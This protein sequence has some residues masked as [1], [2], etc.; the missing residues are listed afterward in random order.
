MPGRSL[1]ALLLCSFAVLAQ[2]QP[3]HTWREG[4]NYFLIQP[5]QPS[6]APPGKVEVTEV[7]SYACP[8][9]N[10]FYPIA[11][12]IKSSLP[13]NAVMDFL[14]AAFNPSEDWPMF[15]R[16]YFTAQALGVAAKTHDAM[17]NAVWKSGEL[18]VVDRASNTLKQ[19][20]PTIEDAARFYHR[21]AGVDEQ[22]FLAVARSFSVDLKMKRADQLIQ[23]YQADST[24]TLVIDGKYRVTPSSAGGYN[25]LLAVVKY[26]VAKESH[27]A[28]P[29]ASRSTP[30]SPALATN[31]RAH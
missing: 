2:A 4:E 28:A 13:S 26:L 25:E 12:R 19:P 6:N 17:F 14:P 15:Q 27:A 9:C 20:A 23:A 11:E 5:P 30:K 8:A 7:F 18:A 16:A 10:A 31:R 1:L 22:Q 29:H 3:E 24:P 21:E